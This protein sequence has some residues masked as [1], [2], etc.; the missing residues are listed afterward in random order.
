MKFLLRVFIFAISKRDHANIFT[1]EAESYKWN[2]TV[3]SDHTFIFTFPTSFK[4]MIDVIP[5]KTSK[6]KENE[7][8][9]NLLYFFL[10]TGLIGWTNQRKPLLY[11]VYSITIYV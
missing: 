3:C 8:F 1:S 5:V 6:S 7:Y 4:I 9:S 11:Y 10:I 2:F